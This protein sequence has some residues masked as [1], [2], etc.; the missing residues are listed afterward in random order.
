MSGAGMSSFGP[1]MGS[2]SDVNRLV[3]RSSSPSDMLCGSQR[4]PP[5]A[6]PYGKRSSEH[7]HVIHIASAAHSPS[8]TLGS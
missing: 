1:M 8:V 5:F 7:F 4:T 3:S 2:S 6:P